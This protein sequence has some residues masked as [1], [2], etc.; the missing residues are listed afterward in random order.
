MK[1]MKKPILILILFLIVG[2]FYSCRNK[3]STLTKVTIKNIMCN[4]K[5]GNNFMSHEPILL[6]WDPISLEFKNYILP[7]ANSDYINEKTYHLPIGLYEI[8]HFTLFELEE[9]QQFHVNNQENMFIETCQDKFDHVNHNPN[10]FID[11]LYIEDFYTIETEL[12]G[13]KECNSTWEIS[14]DHDH[15]YFQSKKINKVLDSLDIDAIKKFESELSYLQNSPSVHANTITFR[16]QDELLR[17]RQYG[18]NWQGFE[19]LFEQLKSN[20][21]EQAD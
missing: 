15:Y 1:E 10:T 2:T 14:R 17:M 18:W 7:K 8:R 13:C 19:V 4:D 6:K 12:Y 20:H 21:K 9:K 16:H 11:K 3:E 5:N